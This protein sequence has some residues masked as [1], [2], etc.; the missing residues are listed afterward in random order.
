[1]ALVKFIKIFHDLK[2][3]FLVNIYE[4]GFPIL[5]DHIF[6]FLVSIL[7]I[8]LYLTDYHQPFELPWRRFLFTLL[9]DVAPPPSA[10]PTPLKRPLLRHLLAVALD[11][12]NRH[13]ENEAGR[14]LRQHVWPILSK[15][16]VI[17]RDVNKGKVKLLITD[18]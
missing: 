9:A 17:A 12:Q 15:A 5:E 3:F 16:K 11:F 13:H 8:R 2:F 4:I 14:Y 18:L 10:F 7:T 6:L 1:M